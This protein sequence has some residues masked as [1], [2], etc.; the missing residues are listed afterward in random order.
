MSFWNA[1]SVMN[2]SLPALCSVHCGRTIGAGVWVP[3]EPEE[4]DDLSLGRDS[5]GRV[6]EIKRWSSDRAVPSARGFSVLGSIMA[7]LSPEEYRARSKM[8]VSRAT[9][10]LGSSI[11]W[12]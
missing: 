10:L 5:G 7:G 11:S 8:E 4:R 6:N 1:K 12:P 3:E 9:M 2:A